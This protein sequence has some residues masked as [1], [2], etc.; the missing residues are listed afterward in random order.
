MSPC[1]YLNESAIRLRYA[2]PRVD[3][4]GTNFFALNS[5]RG[6][7]SEADDPRGETLLPPNTILQSVDLRKRERE[8]SDRHDREK[9]G[10]GAVSLTGSVFA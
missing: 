6:R 1:M 2:P 3:N 10:R 7:P 9:K 4:A 8:T 5:G